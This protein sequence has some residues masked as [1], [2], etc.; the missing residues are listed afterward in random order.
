MAQIVSEVV[1]GKVRYN[2]RTLDE[3][4]PE[5]VTDIV[6]ACDPL[7]VILFGSVAR[8]DHGPDSDL[9]VLVVLPDAPPPTW[10][11]S[12]P[13]FDVPFGHQYPSR[14]ISATSVT[15]NGGG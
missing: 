7:Q 3:W 14:F 4:V 9:D 15:S 11:N 8:G 10:A 2:G 12:Q 5:V 13:T 6:T 1:D